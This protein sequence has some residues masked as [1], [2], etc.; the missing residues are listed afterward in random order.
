MTFRRLIVAALVLFALP[1]EARIA[2][3]TKW[4]CAGTL[5]SPT[6]KIANVGPGLTCAVVG[7][8][9]TLDA[10]GGAGTVDVE[11][12]GVLIGTRHILNFASGATVVDDAPNN[13]V[14]ITVTG[15][16][17]PTCMLTTQTNLPS[18]DDSWNF[19][20]STFRWQNGF[21]SQTVD[22][23][24]DALAATTL[25]GVN[26]H[27]DTAASAPVPVQVSPSLHLAG[28]GYNGA[29]KRRQQLGHLQPRLCVRSRCHR[30]TC[31]SVVAGRWRRSS[32]GHRFTWKQ[33]SHL[34]Q[35]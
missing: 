8:T 5:Q 4:E 20:S 31:A 27:N 26:L 11:Q 28:A 22:V 9:L 1:A 30:P 25:P 14:N 2:A 12:A 32:T 33:Q 13:R 16:A 23:R 15:A 34:H 21:F 24:R 29:I 10:G 3:L 18:V 7:N 19:G 17:C 6:P 35:R